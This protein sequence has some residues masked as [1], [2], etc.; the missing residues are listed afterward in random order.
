MLHFR[1]L[2]PFEVVDDNG[3]ALELGPPQQRAMLALL[4]MWAPATAAVDEIVDALWHTEPPSTARN[5][6]QVY[7]SRL[8]KT[9]GR[10]GGVELVTRPPG[11]ALDV[12]RAGVD[13]QVFVELVTTVSP[14]ESAEDRFDRLTEALD[15]WRGPVLADLR[16][17]DFLAPEIT[18]LEEMRLDAAEARLAA[19]IELG[20]HTEAI[21]DLE[22]FVNDHPLREGAWALLIRG[23]YRTGRQAEA[24]RAYDRVREL[25][26]EELGVD[27]VPELQHLQRAILVHD[28]ALGGT[29]LATDEASRADQAQPAAGA[30]AEALAERLAAV[31]PALL[32]IRPGAG[33][34]R[35][36]VDE[37]AALMATFRQAVEGRVRVALVAGEAGIGKSRLVTESTRQMAEAGAMVLSGT[38]RDGLAAPFEPIV[39]AMRR[40]VDHLGPETVR[41]LGGAAAP[42]LA[43]LLPTLSLP[44]DP[45][46]P[47]RDADAD[48]LALLEAVDLVLSELGA[49]QPLVLVLDDLHWVDRA[50]VPL[51]RHVIASTRRH[52]LLVVGTYRSD[53]VGPEH[54]LQPLISD[55]RRDR[56]GELMELGGLDHGPFSELV[57]ELSHRDLDVDTLWSRTGGNPLFA[58]YLVDQPASTT[59]LPAGVT[60]LIEERLRRLDPH[61][62]EVLH[63]AAIAGERFEAATVAAAMRRPPPDVLGGLDR[64][65]Q[66]RAVDDCDEDGWF[67]F[68]HALT[69]EALIDRLTAAR[70]AVIHWQVGQALSDRALTSAAARNDRAR[71]LFAGV[72]AGNPAEAVAALVE[73]GS[74]ALD[75]LAYET[76]AEHLRAASTL[77]E[78]LPLD[79][80]TRWALLTGRGAV[81]QALGDETGW[82]TAFSAA[83]DL[84][85]EHGWS[86]RL[87]E[88]ALGFA[89]LPRL[90][91]GLVDQDVLDLVDEALLVAEPNSLE[92]FRLVAV[93]TQQLLCG[94]DVVEADTLL[95]QTLIES[96]SSGDRRAVLGP[97]QAQT[98][99]LL[100]SPDA[101]GMISSAIEM[102]SAADEAGD[103]AAR[104]RAL[105]ALG[106]GRLQSGDRRA[107]DRVREQLREAGH[108]AA[109]VTAL[110]WDSAI[111]SAE[112]RL[113][114][115]LVAADAAQ[116]ARPGDAGAA[117]AAGVQ[118]NLMVPLAAGRLDAAGRAVVRFGELMPE[119][120]IAVALRMWMAWLGGEDDEADRLMQHL[121]GDDGGRIPRDWTRPMTLRLLAEVVAGR[122]DRKAATQLAGLLRPYTGQPLV[123]GD[124]VNVEGAADGFL[125]ELEA[126]RGLDDG[127]AARFVA[128]IRQEDE[129]GFAALA[130]R[131]RLAYARELLLAAAAEGPDSPE[132]QARARELMERAAEDAERLGLARLGALARDLRQGDLPV[133]QPVGPT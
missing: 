114:D 5:L 26:L 108:P 17:F 89:Y 13:A 123:T 6:V 59:R 84:A 29:V 79:A 81:A 34:F 76:A 116:A 73:A 42:H 91:P 46:R 22:K 31:P 90:V 41:G 39:L 92:H 72:A 32:P 54:P 74:D 15:L 52:R 85:R 53:E 128:A 97:L 86:H 112:G 12:G 3:Q 14:G 21:G 110:L 100:G 111:A 102:L 57:H 4:T 129:M 51:L 83:A 45:P 58:E 107:F 23:L 132:Q 56:L 18:R 37:R 30:P 16:R 24:L 133:R 64:A 120:P 11:Y 98:Y 8:R 118:K 75:S 20:R 117:V 103:T 95:D 80:Q 94:G 99:R 130:T 88:T 124:G 121:L 62:L 105:V 63:V 119:L 33:T 1:L 50:T 113:D 43:R 106:V 69:R 49:H 36:R 38:S 70:R 28:P 127:V 19:E 25:L 40:L 27:P 9:L 66:E 78:R 44:S 10:L 60:D 67:A 104:H 109:T 122:R 65:I 115:A 71:H 2:G 93:R 77:D 125:A 101:A 126:V 82:R 48:R 35:G 47:P 68:R 61:V 96:R 87:V 7:V 131:T 55:V